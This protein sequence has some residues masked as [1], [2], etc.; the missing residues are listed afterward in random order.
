[1]VGDIAQFKYGNSLPADGILL[2][3]FDIK[4]NEASLTGEAA[5]VKKTVTDNPMILSGTQVCTLHICKV[6][7]PS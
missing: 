6:S 2:S 5:L 1:M 7:R 3:G 4:I